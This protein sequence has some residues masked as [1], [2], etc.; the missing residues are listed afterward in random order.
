MF[1]LL[2]YLG[3]LKQS[4]SKHWSRPDPNEKFNLSMAKYTCAVPNHVSD[5]WGREKVSFLDL[6]V[7][8][9]NFPWGDAT[10]VT[11]PGV[12]DGRSI[13][14]TK[15]QLN[16]P[17]SILWWAVWVRSTYSRN[18]SQTG[19]PRG[20]RVPLT[21]SKSLPRSLLVSALSQVL[22]WSQFS[23]WLGLSLFCSFIAYPFQVGVG[24][25]NPIGFRDFLKLLSVVYLH[26]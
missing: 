4:F 18:D 13:D 16:E 3:R 12:H 22:A 11:C 25:M 19:S 7:V 14:T 9:E 2:L 5:G 20:W 8:W 23:L 21:S 17:M 1:L 26:G 15:A 10:H 24:G 6:F